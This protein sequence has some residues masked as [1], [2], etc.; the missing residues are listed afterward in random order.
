MPRSHFAW[1]S[2]RPLAVR[3]LVDRGMLAPL[4]IA[5][6]IASLAFL[7]AALWLR[8]NYLTSAAFSEY[9]PVLQGSLQ[10]GHTHAIVAALQ[11]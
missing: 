1:G 9:L 3:T 5:L 11:A 10:V 2:G 8:A 4:T 7:A 6:A